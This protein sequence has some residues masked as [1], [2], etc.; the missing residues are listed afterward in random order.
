[1]S[2]VE[3]DGIPYALACVEA[4]GHTAPAALDNVIDESAQ[5]VA[6]RTRVRM[7]MGPVQ[8]GHLR[9]DVGVERGELQAKVSH[10]GPRFP[11]A[12][13]LEFGGNVGRRHAV[14]RQWIPGGRY[15]YPALRTVRP[16]L[17]PRMHE[18][19]REA[20]REAGWDPSG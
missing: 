10:G 11:Y 9:N 19:M 8:H 14:H 3:W 15:L 2:E 16:G 20:A 5:E 7:P 1:M 13:W 12:G 6:Q 18:A 4:I 17:E